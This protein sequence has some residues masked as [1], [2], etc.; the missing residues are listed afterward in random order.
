M[1]GGGEES[2]VR[3][4][5]YHLSIYPKTSMPHVKLC[6]PRFFLLSAP[7][8]RQF[9][10]RPLRNELRDGDNNGVVFTSI[11]FTLSPSPSSSRS[12][13]WKSKLWTLDTRINNRFKP[14][15]RR[16]RSGIKISLPGVGTNPQRG[17]RHGE[18]R[19]RERGR[20]TLWSAA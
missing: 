10:C 15:R 8:L 17:R 7:F 2:H 20:G 13:Y 1:W 4:T 9:E 16:R 18:G 6:L 5:T 12:S 11:L 19:G 3:V 14:L